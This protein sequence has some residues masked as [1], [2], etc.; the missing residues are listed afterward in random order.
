M[1]QYEPLSIGVVDPRISPQQDSVEIT[2]R[3][4]K[5]DTI[6][7]RLQA[8]GFSRPRPGEGLQAYLD[9]LHIVRY[10]GDGRAPATISEARELYQN[11]VDIEDPRKWP[12]FIQWCKRFNYKPS[13]EESLDKFERTFQGFYDSV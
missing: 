5:P 1:I 13:E 10:S 7:R 4:Q 11:Y 9:S 6:Y 3:G 12:L 8:K 2:L